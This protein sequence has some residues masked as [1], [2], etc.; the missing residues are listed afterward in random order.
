MRF[1]ALMVNRSTFFALIVKLAADPCIIPKCFVSTIPAATLEFE[2]TATGPPHQLGSL[3]D[4]DRIN[5]FY[6]AESHIKLFYITFDNI[7]FEHLYI[8]F[9]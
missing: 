7:I 6:I 9:I 1:I 2:G 3:G 4:K 8:I 5:G